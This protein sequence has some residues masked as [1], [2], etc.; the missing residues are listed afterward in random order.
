MK[1]PKCGNELEKGNMYCEICGEE[2][3][4]VPDFEPEIENSIIETLSTVA[5][6]VQPSDSDAKI[7]EDK[8][9]EI[10]KNQNKRKILIGCIICALLFV[11]GVIIV[12]MVL[13][14]DGSEKRLVSKAQEKYKLNHYAEAAKYYEEAIRKEDKLTY[15]AELA[16]CYTMMGKSNEAETIYLELI[17]LDETEDNKEIIQLAYARLIQ[18]YEK[19]G[20]YNAINSLLLAAKDEKVRKEFESY[21]SP[22]P[23]F[24]YE[25]G[26]YDE[27]IPLKLTAPSHGNVYY[28]ID[29]TTPGKGSFVYTAPIFL[30]KGFYEIKAVYVNDY[31]ISSEIASRTFNIKA[32]MPDV[33][34]I[35]PDNGTFNLPQMIAVSIPEGCNVYYSIDGS[36]PTKN[37]LIYGEPIPMPIGE[38]HYRFVAI[39]KDA[40]AGE[41]VERK[42]TLN[43]IA[44]LSAQDAINNVRFRLVQINRLLDAEGN[45]EGR[46]G[47]NIYVYDSLRMID[48]VTLYF[49][50]EYYQENHSSRNM[51]GNIYGVDI[52]EGRVYDVKKE[53]D[54]SY[55]I[56]PI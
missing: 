44:N 33:P 49:I 38:S 25:E 9:K 53:A 50:N 19:T 18:I 21:M 2:I 7:A 23:D 55:S 45:L 56:A 10:Q 8:E 20:A 54:G 12:A 32:D 15:H 13:F 22:P 11:S 39:N 42:Y 43:V 28:T 3:H 26:E 46:E 52:N 16:D 40:T 48:G 29:G 35:S 30:K 5:M 41:I 51:T 37:S 36:I 47:K 24:S 4:I 1:C 6:E 31:G 17:Q 27:V 34:L 14:L